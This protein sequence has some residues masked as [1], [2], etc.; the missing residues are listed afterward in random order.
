MCWFHQWGNWKWHLQQPF[1]TKG[2]KR[3]QQ[4]NRKKVVNI[5]EK[6]PR[7]IT[8][9]VVVISWLPPEETERERD[10]EISEQNWQLMSKCSRKGNHGK[11]IWPVLFA[12]LQWDNKKCRTSIKEA[13][14]KPNSKAVHIYHYLYQCHKNRGSVCSIHYSLSPCHGFL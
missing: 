7:V 11:R 6:A 12:L 4:M 5:L 14:T 10:R 8:Q 3:I 2:A 1:G 9:A 13:P